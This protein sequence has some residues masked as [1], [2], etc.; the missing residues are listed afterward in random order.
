MNK[1]IKV[2]F[3]I[4]CSILSCTSFFLINSIDLIPKKYFILI[5]F[6]FIFLNTLIFIFNII[7][8]KVLNII[9]IILEFIIILITLILY[10]S[11]TKIPVLTYHDFV[12]GNPTNEMQ[13]NKKVF[14]K[15]MMYLNKMGY[16]TLKLEDIK[17]F[18]ESKCDISKK[19][20]LIT[21]DDGWKS[22]LE[23]ALPILKKYNLNAVIFYLGEN[24]DGKNENFMNLDDLKK[25]KEEYDNIEIASHSYSLHYDD[26]Y[27]L[28]LS[29][30]VSD[31]KKMKKVID[32]KYYAYPCGL[33]SQK[34]MDALE[35]EKYSLAFTFGQ[36]NTHRKLTK[37]DNRYEL[38]RL[39]FSTDMPLWKFVLRLNW[40]K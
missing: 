1:K 36:N 15:Q 34:Y 32:S 20:V 40:Y 4:I 6:C 10:F 38:P 18:I 9:G 23:I 29:G 12:D 25:I 5:I 17:C 30:F 13:I 28:D 11:P 8:K 35:K 24:Y 3:G 16:K 37:K 7:N 2:I 26:A 39:N 22:E 31:M 19:S 21:I 33:Y 14:E 27:M